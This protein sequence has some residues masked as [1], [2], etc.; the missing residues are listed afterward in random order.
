MEI[1]WIN[2]EMGSLGWDR[3]KRPQIPPPHSPPFAPLNPPPPLQLTHIR[4]EPEALLRTLG[5]K[6]K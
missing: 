4:T 2:I 6:G 1:Q 5:L 3:G